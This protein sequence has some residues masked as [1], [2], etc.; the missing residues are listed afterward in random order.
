MKKY[1]FMLNIVIGIFI[2]GTSLIGLYAIP[3][4]L[5]MHPFDQGLA[6]ALVVTYFYLIATPFI[7]AL[8]ICLMILKK[9]HIK[10]LFSHEIG[11]NLIK[12]KKAA[13]I[14]S[15]ISILYCPV[16]IFMAEIEDAPGLGVIGLLML[17]LCVGIYAFLSLWIH[18]TTR[19]F[20]IEE[21]I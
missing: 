2:L 14:V 5:V 16:F 9:I 17:L 12:I 8:V 11:L 3:Y 19:D 4:S 21:H 10:S 6:D 20:K 7:Y 13:L 1:I 15:I 18:L